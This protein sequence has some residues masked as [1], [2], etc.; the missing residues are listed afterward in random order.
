MLKFFFFYISGY[1]YYPNTNRCYGAHRQGP[2]ANGQKLTLPTN[3]NIPE[4]RQNFCRE[5]GLVQLNRMCYKLN[6]P[7]PCENPELS[8]VL[9]IDTR[10]FALKC[11]RSSDVKFPML[12]TRF[13][14]DE[15][16]ETETQSKYAVDDVECRI[17]SRRSYNGKC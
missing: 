12:T 11:I 13:G 6:E 5:D 1:L 9:G 8:N 16:E 17:G 10:T 4:C 2:C 15:D 14:D 3:R 7:G